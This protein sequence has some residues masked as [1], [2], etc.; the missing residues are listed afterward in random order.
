M[1]HLTRN[2]VVTVSLVLLGLALT[3]CQ[4]VSNTRA[5]F[6]QTLRDVGTSATELKSAK[7]D[8]PV[9]QVKARRGR[10]SIFPRPGCPMCPGGSKASS[11]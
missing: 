4:Q 9:D 3:G 2:Y 11:A 5:E 10:W 6:C 7:I 8:Q 1:R